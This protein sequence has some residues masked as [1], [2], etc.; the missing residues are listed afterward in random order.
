MLHQGAV[1]KF[2]ETFLA[3]D[4]DVDG[5]MEL[6]HPDCEWT[7]MATG[8]TFKGSAKI[9]ELA[10]RSVAARVHTEKIKME[11]TSLFTTEEHFV[12]EYLHR[13]IVTADWPASENRP[14]A[15]TVL[16]I[17]ICIVAHFK[18]EKLDWLHEYFDLAT[19]SGKLGQKLY[20]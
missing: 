9:R 15:G 19:V 8:E 6:I 16:D 20:S 17:P 11:P 3:V 7:L 2:K 18:G 4:S 10:E 13:A 14:A 12:I 1:K 5:F